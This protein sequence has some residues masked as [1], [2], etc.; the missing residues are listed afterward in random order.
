MFN[1]AYRIASD[2]F[3]LIRI[4]ILE[5]RAIG[6][7][8]SL[9]EITRSTA[10]DNRC[11]VKTTAC[12]I[13]PLYSTF[14]RLQ[15]STNKYAFSSAVKYIYLKSKI[16]IKC[17][18]QN[19]QLCYHCQGR[20]LPSL[21]NFSGV[22]HLWVYYRAYMDEFLSFNF[23]ISLWSKLW[24][25]IN[26]HR[27]DIRSYSC[28]HGDESAVTKLMA[29]DI[30]IDAILKSTRLACTPRDLRAHPLHHIDPFI[31]L[32]RFISVFY[33]KFTDT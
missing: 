23:Y 12:M 6:K 27:T 28:A 29:D 7:Q 8:F 3:L 22:Y 32:F 9:C 30:I 17:I 25:N 31:N 2:I 14:L 10:C 4:Q 5:L 15:R 11:L 20:A 26:F 33:N 16:K 24:Q 21:Q 18:R 1:F 13:L 19:A